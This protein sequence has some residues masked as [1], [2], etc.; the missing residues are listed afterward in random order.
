MSLITG[1]ISGSRD[2]TMRH[3]DHFCLLLL[4]L[5]FVP[6]GGSYQVSMP[7]APT[8]SRRGWHR[9][10]PG[11]PRVVLYAEGDGARQP[12]TDIQFSEGYEVGGEP[13]SSLGAGLLGALRETHVRQVKA[14][15][16]S[17]LLGALQVTANT[18]LLS[19]IMTSTAQ[20][21]RAVAE[22][23]Q[24]LRAV[25]ALTSSPN[26]GG[27]P[28]TA[29]QDAMGI[30]HHAKDELDEIAEEIVLGDASGVR[31]LES[32]LGDL[33]FN[34]LLLIN[35]CE[36]DGLGGASLEGA[37]ASASA[38][39]RRRAPFLFGVGQ[40][41]QTPAEANAIWKAVKKQEKAGLIDTVPVPLQHPL[42]LGPPPARRNGESATRPDGV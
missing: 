12:N 7:H 3:A 11:A 16:G 34:T 32:E 21:K 13:V 23:E 33:L 4:L 5:C 39:L 26:E 24:L 18:S 31:A 42:S 35:L 41:P 22:V 14:S 10:H 27:C 37:A 29:E 25:N 19:Q 2:S 15:K 38:K 17:G 20:D 8:V 28:W 40:R 30:I 36:R 1:R 9:C 6:D